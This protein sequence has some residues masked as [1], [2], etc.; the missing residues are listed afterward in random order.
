MFNWGTKRW[1]IIK[2]CLG[3][4]YLIN[5]WMGCNELST[6]N[7][8]LLIHCWSQLLP[9]WLPHTQNTSLCLKKNV[10]LTLLFG[11]WCLFPAM[12]WHYDDFWVAASPS[13]KC[14]ATLYRLLVVL[15][16][17]KWH[18]TRIITL[19]GVFKGTNDQSLLN[20]ITNLSMKLD[21]LLRVQQ[22]WMKKKI[23]LIESFVSWTHLINNTNFTIFFIIWHDET[24][25]LIWS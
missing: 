17:W 21:D 14:S 2:V 5:H 8:H 23:C 25:I 1:A 6:L 10:C 19:K 4:A 24:I 7:V 13:W 20:E 15:V 18:R 12:R 3:A 16:A 11:F 22:L 9:R